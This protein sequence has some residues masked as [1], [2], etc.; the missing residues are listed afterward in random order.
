MF[1]FLIFLIKYYFLI[2]KKLD[3]IDVLYSLLNINNQRLEI[4][5]Q[6]QIFS[7]ILNFVSISQ[8]SDQITS[9]PS[10]ILDRFCISILSRIHK[11]VK[12]LILESVS[13]KYILR[14]GNYPNLTQLKLF[15]FTKAIFSRYFI[16]DFL[17]GHICKQQITD[18]VLVV[19]ENNI[20]ITE[21]DY[22]KNVYAIIL[23]FFENVKHL[24]I[25][26]PSTKHYSGSTTSYPCLSLYKLPPMTFS[27]ST[28]TKL[29]INVHDINDVRSLLDGRLK[30]LTTLI[31]QV[32]FI[33]DLRS[34]SYNRDDLPNLKC[35]SL[36]SYNFT[37]E[38]DN[39][40]I[41]LLRRMSHLEE[42]TLNIL[43]F[44][45][46]TLIT[47][48]HLDNE[49]LIHMPRLHTFI[50]CIISE[51]AITDPA[52]RISNDDIERTFSNLKHQQV[53]CMVDYFIPLKMVCRV[54][55]LPF[56]FDRLE[57]VTNNIP[58]IVFKS[59]TRLNLWDKDP[60]KHEF[61]VR[62]TRAFPFLKK[63]SIW[64]IQAPFSTF[65]ERHLSDKD[66]C[67]IVEYPHLI[68]LD[69]ARANTHYVEHFL[70]ETKTH[71]PHLTEL[72]VTYDDLEIV[73]KNF[74]RDE[75]RRSCAGVKRLIVEGPINY[76]NDVYNYFP[77]FHDAKNA[78]RLL[79]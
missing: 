12:S 41:P 61:F 16:D 17:F 38:Y 42:L 32:E 46:S 6:E 8:S 27:S 60:F 68:S 37:Q 44:D 70:N 43:I 13:M 73:T 58:N 3:N 11:N 65:D 24:T 25:A 14:A 76:S 20:E 35:F 40:I 22:T 34:T 71:L 48:T 59:V 78:S 62:L 54:F 33:M 29:C 10:K 72:K 23:D 39:L 28:L 69:V 49:I 74:T 64:N 75:T 53:A 21:E 50:F 77:L 66:W 5:A 57:H 36:T 9:L 1:I 18:L 45:R 4:I 67:S 7:D 2:L 30:Q 19:N 63:L 79:R 15:N 47:G 51:T 26:M 31:V 52:I 55:S 56:K